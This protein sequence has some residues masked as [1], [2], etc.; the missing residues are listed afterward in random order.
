M[1]SK[2]EKQGNKWTFRY[3]EDGTQKRK[4]I[5]V[6]S[7]K[8]AQK[9]QLDFLSQRASPTKLKDVTFQAFCNEYLNYAKTNKRE[10]TA[11]IDSY[12]I[13]RM[14]MYLEQYRIIRLKDINS[15]HTLQKAN[16]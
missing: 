3:Y 2:L 13:K 7:Y 4:T 15:K 5:E 12:A 1:S 10:R 14:L 16:F 8:E 11:L 9:L 6:F